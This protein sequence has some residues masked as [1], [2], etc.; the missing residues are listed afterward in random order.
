METQALKEKMDKIGV[1]VSL[2]CLVHCVVLPLFVT[3]LS[4]A[5]LEIM[6][7]LW[8]EIMMIVIAASA[9]SYAIF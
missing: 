9:G 7:N 4:L 5:G 6:S 1:A 2:G 8:I 3:S